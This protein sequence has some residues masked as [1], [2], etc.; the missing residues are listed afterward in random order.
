MDFYVILGLTADASTAEIKRAYR[1][2][3]R[4]YHPGINPGDRAAEALFQRV[5]EAYETLVDPGRR[6]QYDASGARDMDERGSPSFMFS[7]FD[8]SVT[9][10]GAQASTF[11]ELFADVLHP[12]PSAGPGAVEPGADI[13]ASLTISFDE[14]ARGAERQLVVTRQVVCGG[15]AGTGAVAVTAGKCTHCQGSGQI[16]WA[17]GHMVF[18]KPC[19]TCGGSGRETWQRC[20][21]CA[22]H[23]RTVRSEAVGVMMPPGI[24]DGWQLRLLERGHAG[25]KGGRAGDLHVTV[26]VEPHPTFRREGDDLVCEL[27]VAVHEAVL[28]ARV[29]VPTLEGPVKLRIPPGTQA[30]RRL[31]LE[32]RGVATPAGRRGDLVFEVTLVLPETLDDRSR[33]LMRQFGELN[34]ADVRSGLFKR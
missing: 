18:S 33:A 30:G 12:V 31:R 32:G 15:C 22:G 17:R 5:S 13:H 16:R 9:K 25:A 26:R 28:G 24:T 34:A 29:D 21:V 4:R 3:A 7:E 8:F 6:R 14:A 2:L 19:A 20:A 10:Q 27:P 11:T 23:G 1:R